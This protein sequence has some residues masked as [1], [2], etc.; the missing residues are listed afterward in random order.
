MAELSTQ[1]AEE[2][3]PFYQA[4]N[5]KTEILLIIA[6]WPTFGFEL[7]QQAPWALM[8]YQVAQIVAWVGLV[9]LL[10]VWDR[11]RHIQVPN[12]LDRHHFVE[13]L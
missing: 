9:V 8:A 11:E 1:F 13:L 7:R 3:L 6:L 4:L 2:F 10:Q 12:V 5:I